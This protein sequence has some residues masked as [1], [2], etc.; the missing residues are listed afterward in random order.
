MVDLRGNVQTRL[1][2]LADNTHWQGAIFAAAGLERLGIRPDN[3]LDLDWML[4]AP[5]QGAIAVY[6]RADDDRLLAIC[7]N[8]NDAPTALCTDIERAFL[9][10]LLGGCSAPISAV[11]TIE[12][13]EVHF[14]GNVLSH[15]CR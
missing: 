7:Q 10:T 1:Q 8:M 12:N 9:K 6:C 4:P 3:S 14:K 11:A 2:K 15:C 13:G 5:A